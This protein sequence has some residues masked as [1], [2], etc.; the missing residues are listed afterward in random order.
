MSLNRRLTLSAVLVCGALVSGALV[1][2]AKDETAKSQSKT[3]PAKMEMD[4][5]EMQQMWMDYGVPGPEHKEMAKRAGSWEATFVDYTTPE[6]TTSK[7]TVKRSMM[8][9][10]KYM[11]EEI[12]SSFKW[13]GKEYPF[14][15]IGTLGFDKGSKEYFYFWIDSM[16]T[17]YAFTHGKP[18]ENNTTEMDGRMTSPMGMM[19]TRVEV[20]MV[21][22][23]T[24]T[25]VMYSDMNHDGKEEKCMMITY[26]RK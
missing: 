12:K 7:G 25:M 22:D 24:D 2:C 23:D 6:P 17:G 18:G 11:R 9:D 3:A 10:G 21:D 1:G 13:D 15:G 26:K 4:Q 5:A 8:F 20:T 14:T 19:T 16:G